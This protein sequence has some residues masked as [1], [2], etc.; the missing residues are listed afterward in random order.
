MRP[1]T[2]DPPLRCST[3]KLLLKLVHEDFAAVFKS[4]KV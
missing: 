2:A 3:E 1:E 4:V